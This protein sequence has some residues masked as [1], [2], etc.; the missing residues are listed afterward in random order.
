MKIKT[1]L[2]LQFTLVVTG[3]LI[4]FSLLVY[5]FWFSK[6]QTK[7]RDNLLS[8]VKNISTMFFN[9]PENDSAELLKIHRNILSWRNEEIVITDSAFNIIYSNRANHLASNILEKQ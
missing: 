7:Y 9:I 2:A 3:I 5:F 1:R 8:T 6:Q 4:I